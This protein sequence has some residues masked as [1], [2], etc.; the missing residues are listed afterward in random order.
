MTKEKASLVFDAA[1]IE[2]NFVEL[3]KAARDAGVTPLFALKS[4][5]HPVVRELA[6]AHLTGFDAASAG[7]IDTLAPRADRILSVVDPSGAAVTTSWPGRLIVGVETPEQAAAAPAR[8]PSGY[9]FITD[10]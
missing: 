9:T 1:R 5:P 3:A 4:F 6:A 7:E 10:P 8:G 2:L